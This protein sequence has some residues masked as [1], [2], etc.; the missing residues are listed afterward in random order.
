LALSRNACEPP[1]LG[2]R[3]FVATWQSRQ[4]EQFPADP[5]DFGEPV[6][7][8]TARGR[9]HR[10]DLAVMERGGVCQTLVVEVAESK[11]QQ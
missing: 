9:V 1:A 6:D 4:Q 11:V 3:Q 5:D 8:H 2:Q 10:V 7:H